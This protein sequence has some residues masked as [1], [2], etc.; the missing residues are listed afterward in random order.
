MA[1]NYENIKTQIET[2]RTIRRSGRVS[3]VVGLTIESEGPAVSIGELCF[4]ERLETGE[5]IEAEVVGFRGSN[6][7]LMPLGELRGITPGAIVTSTGDQLRVKVGREL[8]GRTLNGLGRPID[9]LGPLKAIESMTVDAAPPEA[10]SR[11]LIKERLITGIR[12][13]DLTCT[14]GQGQR[15]GIF[16]GSGV[17]KSV[18][19]GMMARNSTADIN[20]IAL[21][22]ERGREVREFLVDDLGEEGLARSVVVCVTS[23]ETPLLRLKGAMTA[24]T[25]AEYFR[26]Q[27]M[28]TLLMMDS[29]TRVAMAQREIGLATGEPPATKGYTPSVYAVLPRLLE[30]AG[31]TAKGSVT[32]FY[33][34]LV[35]GDDMNEPVSDL[36]RSI[37]DG[38]IALS[39][40]LA[41]RNQYPAVDIL[42][43]VS[44]LMKNVT[45]PELMAL[46][47]EV[48]EIY[49]IY[50]DAEDLINIGAYTKGSSVKIDRAIELIEPLNEFFRQGIDERSDF[51]ESIERLKQILA[52]NPR[53]NATP[54][55][56]DSALKAVTGNENVLVST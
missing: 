29:I 49:S 14:C 23:D 22:G 45:D 28:N 55:E 38:H 56:S 48:R 2:A 37:L 53:E 47:G 9:G 36:A 39:R 16:A 26:N 52:Y 24:T 15:M 5:R 50:N 54:A 10:L 12:S 7:L 11:P 21:I 17:G 20:V 43:S 3:Q 19:M 4:I 51:S 8:V 33:T 30:R 46:A 42:Q 27:G 40:K 18:T 31:A 13:L 32:G 44:R 34:V 6:L 1:L 41:A 35:E 25:I